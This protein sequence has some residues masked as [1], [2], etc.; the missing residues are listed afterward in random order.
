VAAAGAAGLSHFRYFSV[1]E[2]VVLSAAV[3]A[4]DLYFFIFYFFG[5]GLM[6]NSS[7][8]RGFTLVELLV[9]IAIIGILIALLLPAIQAAR[10]AARR[11]TCIN[12]LKQLGLAFHNFHDAN[13]RLPPSAMLC[14][15]SPVNAPP[16]TAGGPSFLVRLLPMMEYGSMYDGLINDM[17]NASMKRT[18][19]F[20]LGAAGLSNNWL[21]ARDTVLQ[22]LICP[23]NPNR[24]KGFPT[25][26]INPP[27]QQM[28]LTNYKAMGSSTMESLTYAL[29]PNQ[30]TP[31]AYP[32]LT[33]VPQ[34]H[35]DGA[36]FPGSGSRFADF[37]DGTAHT[38]MAVETMDDSIVSV[39]GRNVP[40]SCWMAGACVTL[41]GVPTRI[42]IVTPNLTPK[43]SAASS[44]TYPFIF[45]TGFNGKYYEEASTAIQ[46]LKTYLSYD[47][48]GTDKGKYPEMAS[49]A[50][51]VGIQPQYGPGAA[52]PSVVNHLF[53]D[54]AVRSIR[55]DVDFAMYFFS[56]TRNNGDPAGNW[57]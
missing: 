1:S 57:E 46:A 41:A 27:G 14:T 15:T 45:P 10:E 21:N 37:I 5:G 17:N 18:F 23:S 47:F 8:K 20:P 29:N 40:A 26:A 24:Q 13:K 49:A 53:V 12:N 42:T 19:D 9:V 22:E 6:T 38:F 39:S 28:A 31:N 11:A 52:H 34:N 3:V 50:T 56:I 43:W 32:D 4:A 51:I 25:A 48:P 35:P 30:T 54:G 33:S 55:K 2:C 7:R 16:Y 44:S 36:V